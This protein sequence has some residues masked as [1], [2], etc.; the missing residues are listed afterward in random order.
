MG[1]GLS[2]VTL[3]R[4]AVPTSSAGAE[5]MPR[6]RAAAH[7]AAKLLF[8]GMTRATVRLELPVELGNPLKAGILHA[9]MTG[10]CVKR[11]P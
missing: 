8:S 4:A 7:P 5:Q 2:G 3:S 6:A 1:V 11:E 9:P 10:A